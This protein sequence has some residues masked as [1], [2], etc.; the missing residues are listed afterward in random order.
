MRPALAVAAL[1]LAGCAHA[2]GASP[3]KLCPDCPTT[4]LIP[5]GVTQLGSPPEETAREGLAAS[6]S[7]RERPLRQASVPAFRIGAAEVTRAQFAAFVSATGYAPGKGCW[8]YEGVRWRLDPQRDWADPGI[9]QGRDEPA[10]C[11][12]KTDGQAYAAW[13]TAKT[14]KPHRLPT[15]AEWE[16]AARAG[17]LTARWWGDGFAPEAC[18]RVNSGDLATDRAF[19]WAG[20]SLGFPDIPPWRPTACDDGFAATAPAGALEPN[21]FGLRHMLGN[22]QEWTADSWR[23]SPDSPADPSHAAL[24]GQGWTGSA[25]V[26]RSAFRL[27]GPV[28]ERRFT[29]GLRIAREAD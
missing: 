4:V 22:V 16:R 8:V 25:A 9:P 12:S 24:R 23:D 26:I 2:P 28:E 6:F 7:A 20:K 19:G 14:G 18:A 27:K 10:V 3:E 21:P 1:A 5:A 13:L 15:E 29:W 17:S 11:L